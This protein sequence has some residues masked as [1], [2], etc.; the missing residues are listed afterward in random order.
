[1]VTIEKKSLKV[2]KYVDTAHVDKVISTY[3]KERWVHNTKRIGKED[4]LSGWY[5]VEELEGFIE[6]I[7]QHGADGI[8]MYFAAY[9]SDYAETPDYAG[10]QTIV[11]VATKS[12]ETPNGGTLNKDVYVTDGDKTNILAYNASRLCPPY[13]GGGGPPESGDSEWGGLGLALVDRG[14]GELTVI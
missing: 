8:K 1:M 10:R 5:S 9:P 7:K 13:C 4:S 11:L 6:N 12:K 2:G 14:D 3:K